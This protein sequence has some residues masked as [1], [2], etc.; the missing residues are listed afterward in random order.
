MSVYGCA[1]MN[2]LVCLVYRKYT[3]RKAIEDVEKDK[4]IRQQNYKEKKK[5]A[6]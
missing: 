3:Y 5:K 1:R 6:V 2:R 4:Q